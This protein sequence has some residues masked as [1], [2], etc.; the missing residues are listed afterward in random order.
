MENNELEGLQLGI[1]AGSKTDKGAIEES[2]M[3][4]ILMELKIKWN[5]SYL[6][7][8]RHDEE[9]RKRLKE[10]L[11]LGATCFIG[12]ASLNAALPRA[13]ASKIGNEYP[14][15]GVPLIAS[16]GFSNGQDALFAMLRCPPGTVVSVNGVGGMGL[17]NTVLAVAQVIRLI[18]QDVEKALTEYFKNHKK[19]P[20]YN[21][22]NWKTYKGKG[23]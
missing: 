15:H 16:D 22:E 6:S 17:N 12:I 20:V 11:G 8:H 9:L 1:I 3:L 13:I 19:N 18:D 23:K 14:V 5:L 21:A 7:A 2:G 10:M 4:D